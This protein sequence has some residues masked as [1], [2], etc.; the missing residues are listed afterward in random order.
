MHDLYKCLYQPWLQRALARYHLS[1]SIT[2]CFR[3]FTPAASRK[4]I[5][6]QSI[7]TLRTLH[8]GVVIQCHIYIHVYIHVHTCIYIHTDFLIQDSRF[9]PLFLF[10]KSSG[11]CM[12]VLFC[13]FFLTCTYATEHYAC[14]CSHTCVHVQCIWY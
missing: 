14:D 12:V 3:A 1:K 9:L 4:L 11:S 2:S 5:G 7:T 8:H 6:P 10:S 13:V